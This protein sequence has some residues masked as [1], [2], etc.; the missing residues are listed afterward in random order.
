MHTAADGF[1]P[2]SRLRMSRPAIPPGFVRR[3]RLD[4][5]LSKGVEGPVTVVCAGPG[6]GKTL[7]VAAWARLRTAPGPI[8]WLLADETDDVQ[9]FWTQ[10]LGALTV[11]DALPGDSPLRAILPGTEFGL[12]EVA[13]IADELER[14]PAPVVFVIDDVHRITDTAVLETLSHLLD[15]RPTQL[16]LV[17]VSRTEP[18]LHLR[19]LQLSG[20]L[21]E[22]HADALAFTEAEAHEFCARGGF[23]LTT[24]EITMLL[25][26]TQGWPAGLR[27]AL[28]SIDP[29]DVGSGLQRFS[30][31]SRLVAA[32]L[33]EELLETLAPTDRRFLL[34]TSIV[35]QV[36]GGLARALTGRA[37]SHQA[38]ERL[39]ANNALTVR[40]ADRPDWFSYHPLLRQLLRSRLAADQPDSVFDLN[41]RAAAWFTESGD[42][43]TAI[44]HYTRAR[45][46]PAIT[47]LLG[48]VAIPLIVTP[49]AT[50]L[51]A[52]LA[53]AHAEAARHPTSD[54]LLAA[55]VYEYRRRNYEAMRRDVDD[56][57]AL[58]A[59]APENSDRPARLLIALVRMAYARTRNPADLFA[60]SEQVLHLVRATPRDRLPAADAYAVIGT[61]NRAIG[62][63]LAGR[64]D[65]GEAAL[66]QIRTRARGAGLYLTELAAT[67]Y[68]AV[69][70]V[71]FGRIPTARERT[72]SAAEL[73]NQRGWSREPQPLATYSAAALTFLEANDLTRVDEWIEFGLATATPGSDSPAVIL[74]EIASVT[75]AIARTDVFAATAAAGRLRGTRDAIGRLPTMLERWTVVALADAALLEGRPEAVL[76]AVEDPGDETGYAPALERI[77]LA[78]AHLATS[79]PNAALDSLCPSARFAPYRV[80]AA[81]AAVLGAVAASELRRDAVSLARITAAVELAQPIGVVRPFITAGARVPMLLNRYQHVVG[82]HSAFVRNL[83]AACGAVSAAPAAHSNGAAEQLTER[84]LVVLRYLPTMFKTSE[85][86]SDLF[87]SVNTVKT[88][89]QSIYRKLGVSTRRGAVDRARALDLLP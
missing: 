8:A 58:L 27:L 76:A 17:L 66:R 1:T 14:L 62:L 18:V 67:S 7:A 44:R 78:K 61:T 35:E 3:S 51:A 9:A 88:H 80:L 26:R 4:A 81:E 28:L 22:I 77:V 2:G 10:L 36:S 12:L 72:A 60:R 38:L 68:L 84:E 54:T 33:I 89:Q 16:R 75:V 49:H 41:R 57:D 82:A 50:A 31:R 23:E 32:Y 40:L 24:D 37:D 6:F 85:I 65:E 25:T 21:T 42:P 43:I 71:L 45:D 11:A 56:A 19:R 34:A 59:D 47:R 74:L 69:I 79:H 48:E 15:R 64:L 53:P 46:W 5:L 70:D 39:V 13:R 20:D 87:V 73:A 30:G 63:T 55:A 29:N 83:L 86:A 52:A